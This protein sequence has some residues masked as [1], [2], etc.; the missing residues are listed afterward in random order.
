MQ[1]SRRRFTR[2]QLSQFI[3]D[4]VLVILMLAVLC[5]CAAAIMPAFSA[6]RP[7]P[8]VI[9]EFN[10]MIEKDAVPGATLIVFRNGRQ[11]YRIDAG[12]DP[13]AQLP[14]ASASKWM[15]AALI[16][17]L[18]D[19]GKLSL[20]EPIER[21]LPAF[22]GVAG[23]ITLRQILSYTSGQG[24]LQGL[25]DIRQNPRMSLAEAA[26]EIAARPLQDRPGQVFRYGSPAF[27]VAGA[28]AEQ[29]TGE[30]WA[31]LFETRIARPLGLQHSY[32]GNPMWPE[33]SP[34][35]V[36]N[37]NLQ[38]GLVTTAEDYGR[39]LTMLASGGTYE[40]RR[41]LSKRAIE[42]MER[43]QT[44]NARAGFKPYGA[45]AMLQYALGNW[46]EKIEPDQSC[47]VVSSPGALGTYP[48]IDRQNG[49]YG[50]FFMRRRL[51]IVEKDIQTIRR[52][53]AQTD[54]HAER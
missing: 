26:N 19:D 40:G 9:G 37:P 3:W 32:W 45:N 2:W 28:L 30:T 33:L 23:K 43:V 39:L 36:R 5:L 15:A 20:D 17:T 14:V 8:A 4:T 18:V 50:L 7:P 16:M 13:D 29:A 51:P 48:W 41:I 27:Q 54:L 31:R 53:I 42:E 34:S 44:G 11:L 25:V 46:C 38:G 52:L 49:L 10:R 12:I 24:S 1:I 35:Q 22:T 6:S 47:S 21:R